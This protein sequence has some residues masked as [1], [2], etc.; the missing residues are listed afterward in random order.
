MKKK[1]VRRNI[2][3]VSKEEWKALVKAQEL[4]RTQLLRS[5]M[6]TGTGTGAS[7][8]GFIGNYSGDGMI[9]GDISF[10]G[11][12][13]SFGGYVFCTAY[14]N[15]NMNSSLTSALFSFHLIA[16]G[17]FEENEEYG[18]ITLQGNSIDGSVY[19]TSLGSETASATLHNV[20][21]TITR[22][23]TVQDEEGNI[24]EIQLSSVEKTF[25]L[26]LSVS[27]S[28]FDSMTHTF[29]CEGHGSGHEVPTD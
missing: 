16:G 17:G 14:V 29:N 21:L 3:V 19:A 22:T 7:E 4:N 20:I 13:W 2:N 5:G 6:G 12:T 10:G 23:A 18:T 8:G 27:I 25:N 11:I 9:T 15:N 1:T 24:T 28:N 26:T